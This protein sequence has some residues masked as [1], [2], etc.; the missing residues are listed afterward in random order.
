[1]KLREAFW[2]WGH[3]EGAFTG[4]YGNVP[5]SRMTPMEALTKLYDLQMKLN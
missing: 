4:Q 2:Q 1:M 5:P 3:P